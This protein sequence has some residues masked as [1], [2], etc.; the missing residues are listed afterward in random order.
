MIL[1]NASPKYIRSKYGRALQL[2]SSL[3]L[4]FKKGDVEDLKTLPSQVYTVFVGII[5]KRSLVRNKPIFDDH[6]FC[7]VGYMY[8]VK[9]LTERCHEC[10]FLIDFKKTFDSTELSAVSTF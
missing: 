10:Q 8:V 9:Q 2:F 5:L 4:L 7:T 6:N 3:I 1:F